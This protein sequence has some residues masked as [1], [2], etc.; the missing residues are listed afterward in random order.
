MTRGDA[1][2]FAVA[3]VIA[4]AILWSVIPAHAQTTIRKVGSV[5]IVSEPG[6]PTV[7]CKPLGSTTICQP[8]G[9]PDPKPEDH[10]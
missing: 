7:M 9:S 1:I 8:I 10:E 6:R 2:R 4:V 5:E 3:F